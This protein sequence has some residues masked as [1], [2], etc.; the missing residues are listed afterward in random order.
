MKPLRN[1][2]KHSLSR[3]AELCRKEGHQGD[4]ETIE[5]VIHYLEGPEGVKDKDRATHIQKDSS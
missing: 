3:G 4:A 1:D 2:W 5:D